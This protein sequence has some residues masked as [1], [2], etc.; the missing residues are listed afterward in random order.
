MQV[1][2]RGTD[3]AVVCRVVPPNRDLGAVAHVAQ[4]PPVVAQCGRTRRRVARCDGG[5]PLERPAEPS[6]IAAAIAFL[7]SDDASC[8]TGTELLVDGGLHVG[9]MVNPRHLSPAH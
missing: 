2:D 9:T 4:R 6:E 1:H 5:L 8:C 7:V 3:T